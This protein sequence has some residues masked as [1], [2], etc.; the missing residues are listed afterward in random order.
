MNGGGCWGRGLSF[1]NGT[2]RDGEV[3]W[4][5]EKVT[6]CCWEWLEDAGR[7]WD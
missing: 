3:W 7:G 6:P 5:E 1:L 2:E 4:V